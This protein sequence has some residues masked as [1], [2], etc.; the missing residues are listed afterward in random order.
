MKDQLE[1]R[2]SMWSESVLSA[3][4]NGMVQRRRLFRRAGY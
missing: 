1:A 2:S 4:E 3:D